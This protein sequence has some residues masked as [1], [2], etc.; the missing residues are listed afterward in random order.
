MLRV[1][2]SSRCV[3]CYRCGSRRRDIGHD[4]NLGPT[5]GA[6]RSRTI[7]YSLRQSIHLEDSLLQTLNMLFSFEGLSAMRRV[8]Q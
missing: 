6:L 5:L 2:S 1:G 4:S 7:E 8:R 3:T